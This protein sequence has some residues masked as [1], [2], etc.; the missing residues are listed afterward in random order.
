MEH[1]Q[2]VE[3]FAVRD[4]L[5]LGIYQIYNTSHTLRYQIAVIFKEFQEPLFGHPYC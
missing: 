2:F 5:T 4:L 1:E 3:L